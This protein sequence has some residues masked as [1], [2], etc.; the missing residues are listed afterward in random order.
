[1]KNPEIS[2]PNQFLNF[3]SAKVPDVWKAVDYYRHERGSG[4]DG[5]DMRV[6][7]PTSDWEAVI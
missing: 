1:M 5:W 3:F 7:M 6:F 2:V 4:E